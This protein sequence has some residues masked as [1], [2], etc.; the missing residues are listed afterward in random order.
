MA[1]FVP[2]LLTIVARVEADVQGRMRT[3]PLLKRSVLS[4]LA[5]VLAASAHQLHGHVDYVARNLLPDTAERENLDRW[6]SILE[7][8]RKPAAS[9]RGLVTLTGVNGSVVPARRRLR[10]ADGVEYQTDAAT[11]L[12]GGTGAAAVT[13][14]KPGA[15]GNAPVGTPLTLAAT[16]SGVS[17]TAIATNGID[18]GVDVED[19]EQLRAR[20]LK[21]FRN[22]AGA[23]SA[24]N[25]EE[26]ALEVSEVTRAWCLPQIQGPHTVGLT[27][28]VD[29]N[30]AGPIPS[31][32][33][34]D[35]V[36]AHVNAL[37]PVGALLVVFP[38]QALVV[39]VVVLVR[40][41]T[42]AVRDA[43]VAS[44]Q[45]LFRRAAA[46]GSTL[47]LSQIRAAISEAPG[48]VDNTIQAPESDVVPTAGQLPVLGT[49]TFL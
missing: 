30:Q 40:P 12:D 28:V 41:G 22:P 37:R 33:K 18:G 23:G 4:V 15:Q 38:P 7:R 11:V 19:D 5:R 44:L 29:G 46:P 47:Y 9:A 21:R 14:T 45:D 32:A 42:Q 39:N 31:S 48:E 36:R 34:V 3:G 43:V 24:S 25:Y 1:W 17:S 49:V 27:F 2:S 16:V 20:V 10:R 26:W 35:E 8:P 6:A 13:C